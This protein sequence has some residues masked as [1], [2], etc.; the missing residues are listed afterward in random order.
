MY[1]IFFMAA[2][3]PSLSISIAIADFIVSLSCCQ[4]NLTDGRLLGKLRNVI[5]YDLHIHSNR[6]RSALLAAQL[7]WTLDFLDCSNIYMYKIWIIKTTYIRNIKQSLF[8]TLG[9]S[10]YRARL[11]MKRLLWASN[12]N[13]ILMELLWLNLLYIIYIWY[14]LWGISLDFL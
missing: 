7:H 8:V 10:L 9:G 13:R 11:E 5:A 14:N 3:D 1:L 4:A 6:F 12:L 2:L